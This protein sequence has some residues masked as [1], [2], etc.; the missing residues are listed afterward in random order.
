MSEYRC[1]DCCSPN[2]S[3]PYAAECIRFLGSMVTSLAARLSEVE[4]RQAPIVDWERID[5]V[6]R[7]VESWPEWKQRGAGLSGRAVPAPAAPPVEPMVGPI[8]RRCQEAFERGVAALTPEQREDAGIGEKCPSENR[9]KKANC[10]RASCH[11]SA[12][13]TTAAPEKPVRKYV[14]LCMK[15]GSGATGF[16]CSPDDPI[17]DCH[18]CGFRSRGR[19]FAPGQAPEKPGRVSTPEAYEAMRAALAADAGYR[20]TWVANIAMVLHDRHG[21]TGYAER[22]AAGEDIMNRCFPLDP[23]TKPESSNPSKSSNTSPEPPGAEPACT[24]ASAFWCPRCGD[25]KCPRKPDGDSDLDDRD[26][27]LHGYRSNHPEPPPPA[28]PQGT[29]EAVS[30]ER[31]AGLLQQICDL[32]QQICDYDNEDEL[33]AALFLLGRY[34]AQREAAEKTLNAVHAVNGKLAAELAALRAAA[35]PSDGSA[36]L[37]RLRGAGW[38]VAVHN[39]YRKD[40]RSYTFW[41]LTHADGRWVKGEAETDEEALKMCETAA[42]P[43]E[44]KEK[45]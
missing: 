31:A 22:N 1:L 37:A 36:R 38:M 9:C 33:G 24:S 40:R 16:T 4:A 18:L 43:V 21:I 15:C 23:P 14:P 45:D 17:L 8:T 19:L 6:A 44:T 39:D 35:G 13:L 10:F 2:H 11:V 27:P 12:S 32:L 42:G 3:K 34:I 41:L 30:H 5:R 7:E 25:C 26:C 29:G 20:H 28:A